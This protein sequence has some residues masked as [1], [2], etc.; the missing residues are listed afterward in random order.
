MGPVV[1]DSA[2]AERAV[3]ATT[4]LVLAGLGVRLAGSGRAVDGAGRSDVPAGGSS[5]GARVCLEVVGAS[6]RPGLRC[7]SGALSA[8]DLA[9][10]APCDDDASLRQVNRLLRECPLHGRRL[11]LAP[12]RA[13]GPCVPR[14]TDLPGATRLLL[15]LPVDL[16]TAC[17]EDLEALPGVGPK[18]AEELLRARA[19]RPGRVELRGIAGLGASRRRA[20]ERLLIWSPEPGPHCG[21]AGRAEAVREP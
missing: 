10:R 9:L 18:L 14:L 2:P 12:E 3:L 21:G 5:D 6:G 19:T 11:V 7:A 4:L 16:R 8:A 13:A 20:L 15:G 1:F 17:R